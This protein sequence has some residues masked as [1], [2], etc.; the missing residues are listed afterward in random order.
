MADGGTDMEAEATAAEAAALRRERAVL[1]TWSDLHGF[2]FAKSMRHDRD[3]FIHQ[4]YVTGGGA[5]AAGRTVSFV[6]MEGPR[7]PFG[8]AVVVE[9]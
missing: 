2:G 9:D 6:R 5:P 4:K 3:A 1:V 8:V 7:G